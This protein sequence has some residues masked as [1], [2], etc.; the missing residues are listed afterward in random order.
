MARSD[1]S[2]PLPSYNLPAALR[3]RLARGNVEATVAALPGDEKEMAGYAER[4]QTLLWCEE[5]QLVGDLM[6]FDLTGEGA[7]PL[8]KTD[9]K[10]DATAD[11]GA[12]GLGIKLAQIPTL[13][14]PSRSRSPGPSPSSRPSL[15]P[16]PQTRTP[17]PTPT[18][19]QVGT[20]SIA[21]SWSC[22][23]WPS[24]GR[25][26]WWATRCAPTWKGHMG[27]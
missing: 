26:C 18:P 13:P 8:L 23:A 1:G 24:A 9:A 19:K 3:K 16:S 14:S 10:A 2:V 15:S 17:T 11:G 7:A 27:L 4:W 5:W 21:T 22:V 25:R 20:M 12:G 6:L